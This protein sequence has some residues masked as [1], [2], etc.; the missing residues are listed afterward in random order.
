MSFKVEL[1]QQ[2]QSRPWG[3]EPVELAAWKIK[4][5][6]CSEASDIQGTSEDQVCALLVHMRS[7]TTDGMLKLG[8]EAVELGVRTSRV[9]AM[10]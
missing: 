2:S 6:L 3:P 7:H 1:R 10:F 5:Y 4:S 8:A 9:V